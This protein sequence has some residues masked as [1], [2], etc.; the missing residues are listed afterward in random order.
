[1]RLPKILICS[2]TYDGKNYCL[3]EWINNVKSFNYPSSHYDIYL[4]DNSKTNENAKMMRDKYGIGVHWKDYG[5]KVAF[6]RLAEGHNHCRDK[7]IDG[8]YDFMLHLETDVFPEKDIIQQLL[9][10]RKNVVGA[11]YHISHGAR[12]H[13]CT[14]VKN[15]GE[16]FGGMY[17]NST[18]LLFANH[19]ADGTV[20]RASHIG[21]GCVL[22]HKRIVHNYKFRWE[23]DST[24]S[25]VRDL[26]EYD[27]PAPDTFFMN[28]LSRDNV[29]IYA[30]TGQLAF[31][32]N[33]DDWGVM[34]SKV[35]QSKQE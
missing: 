2:P 6:E 9:M 4:A 33:I 34:A 35:K 28:D 5:D 13:L 30:H 19:F 3:K 11:V 15:Y 31:H 23:H 14:N 7:F 1:M 29:K 24:Y 10:A 27:I 25:K 18:N 16:P 21:L 12:R 32:W 17:A 8:D 22:L 26:S 20:K